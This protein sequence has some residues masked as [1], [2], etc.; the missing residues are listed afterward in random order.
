MAGGLRKNGCPTIRCCLK[1]GSTWKK[2]YME[3]P[4]IK[5]AVN[6]TLEVAS[7][8]MN[9]KSREQSSEDGLIHHYG[10]I[11]FNHPQAKE[12]KLQSRY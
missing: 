10:A 2:T 9:T 4:V 12:K 6:K 8:I 7:G 11:P 3:T 5:E 1:T